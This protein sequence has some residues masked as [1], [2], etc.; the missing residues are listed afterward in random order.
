[1]SRFALVAAIKQKNQNAFQS[2]LRCVRQVAVWYIHHQTLMPNAVPNDV[3]HR[4]EDNEREKE[5]F[6]LMCEK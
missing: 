1:M 2:N 5:R 6:P 4:A 3:H